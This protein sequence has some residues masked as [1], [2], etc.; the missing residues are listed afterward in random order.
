MA[1]EKFKKH[2]KRNLNFP[3]AVAILSRSPKHK[4]YYKKNYER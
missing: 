2:R 3:L 1:R 4:N